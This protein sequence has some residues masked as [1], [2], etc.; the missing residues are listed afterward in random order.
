[1]E[2]TGSGSSYACI[3]GST[4]SPTAPPSSS[5]VAFKISNSTVAA[6]A[7]S[8]LF[9]DCSTERLSNSYAAVAAD[10]SSGVSPGWCNWLISPWPLAERVFAV[11]ELLKKGSPCAGSTELAG[12]A[13]RAT[14]PF[15]SLMKI[16]LSVPMKESLGE[17][18]DGEII[19]CSK[20]GLPPKATPIAVSSPPIWRPVSLPAISCAR[21]P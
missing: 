5:P 8:R 9:P 2:R 11:G 14:R 20:H 4:S 18:V 3:E 21:V 16:E 19:S 1:M 7:S 12:E 10:P 15:S 13:M 6:K 17:E